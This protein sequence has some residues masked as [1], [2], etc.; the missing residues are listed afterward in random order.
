MKE[1][2]VY[3][4]L[5]FFLPVTMYAEI[6]IH[7]SYIANWSMYPSYIQSECYGRIYKQNWVYR[8]RTHIITRRGCNMWPNGSSISSSESNVGKSV[9]NWNGFW[10]KWWLQI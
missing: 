1:G 7:N 5:L 8:V 3:M 2:L 9:P 6:H 10:N 4:K